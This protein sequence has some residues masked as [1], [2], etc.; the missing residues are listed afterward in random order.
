METFDAIDRLAPAFVMVDPF[1][2]AGTPM[3]VFNRLFQN[4]KCEVYVSFMYEA[5]NRFRGRPEFES[6]LAFLFD[7]VT[8]VNVDM[9]AVLDSS[10]V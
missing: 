5:I 2:V 3:E 9:A 4:P 6:H 7:V 1:G 10:L 8:N